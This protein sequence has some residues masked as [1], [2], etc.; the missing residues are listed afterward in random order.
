[1]KLNMIIQ[2]RKKKMHCR[3]G[4]LLI[5]DGSNLAH[6]TYMKFQNLKSSKGVPTGMI[7][8]FLRLLQSYVVRFKPTY[9]VVAF[10]THKSKE[11]NFKKNLLG[12]YKI[13]REEHNRNIS[14]DYEDFNRQSRIVKRMLKF[15]NIPVIWD[16]EGL[17][18]EA[19]DYIAHLAMKHHG[20]VE[21]ISSDKDFC[22]LLRWTKIKIYNPNKEK[23]LNSK[24][25]REI[26][27][28]SPEECVDWL[29]LLGDK[30][31]DI[32]GYSGMG[33]VKTRKFLDEFQSIEAFLK[34]TD[35]NFSGI[36]KDG[37]EDL[38]K[39]NTL[40]IDF[41]RGLEKYPLSNIPVTLDKKSIQYDKLKKILSKYTLYS[42]LREEFIEPFKDVE[43]YNV[44]K[45]ASLRNKKAW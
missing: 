41:Y 26:M 20:K 32:P 3:D 37:L 22:Q 4:L 27:G 11:S 36:D 16:S 44:Y 43:Y 40:L 13:H 12:S 34:N 19:D 24:N 31:D 35:A 33:P 29:C 2:K 28:Y 6:R 25:C 18:H 23:I 10:D 8:G 21:I 5:I 17:G 9:I 15:L 30:S 42:F 1:M 45:Y 39:R 38:Y 14:F 7:Y